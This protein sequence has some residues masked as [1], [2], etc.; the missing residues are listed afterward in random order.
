MD[1]GLGAVNLAAEHL[2]DK[3]PNKAFRG[4]T[5][6]PLKSSSDKKKDSDS[7]SDDRDR[8]DSRDSREERDQPRRGN[9][10][11]SHDDYDY[12]SQGYYP[13]E[14]APY[15]GDPNFANSGKRQSRREIS[16]QYQRDGPY[17]T[18]AMQ[19]DSYYAPPP[20]QNYHKY[21][22]ADYQPQGYN[23][24]GYAPV[25]LDLER[26][27]ILHFNSPPHLQRTLHQAD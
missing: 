25:S 17:E 15:Q 18:P 23:A 13:S 5:Y 11:R 3:I 4:D 2:F 12:R 9:E 1:V 22:P 8:R 6:N 20:G 10:R 14:P 7:G 26:E 16:H 24:G 27:Q 19:Q 21:N